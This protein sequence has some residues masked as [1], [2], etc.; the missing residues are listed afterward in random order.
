[1]GLR[2]GQAQPIKREPVR[3]DVVDAPSSEQPIIYLQLK[4]VLKPGDSVQGFRTLYNNLAMMWEVTALEET[5][6]DPQFKNYGLTDEVFQARW[7][8]DSGRYET[9][10]SWG[11]RRPGKAD[12]DI[13][14]DAIDG[15]VS[16]WHDEPLADSTENIEEVHN[17]WRKAAV[18][19]DDEL[20]VE[21]VSGTKTW[22]IVGGPATKAT[23]I[24]FTLAASLTISDEEVDANV[25]FRSEGDE[26]DG[27]IKVQN[28]KT[29]TVNEYVFSGENGHFGYAMFRPEDE[30]YYMWQLQCPTSS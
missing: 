22:H 16:V 1:M 5:L 18:K 25:D 7:N 9:I 14:E 10:G 23:W 21:F 30:K 27:V 19:Q 3:E 26:P 6:H 2:I 20:F 29:S 8:A 15:V 12:A 11:L 4:A 24:R 13:N 17:T 28:M